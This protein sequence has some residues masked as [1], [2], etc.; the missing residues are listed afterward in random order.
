MDSSADAHF[1]Q[2]L[3]QVAVAKAPDLMR[4]LRGQVR[5]PSE[6]QDL[7]QELYV[8]I[9]K[10]KSLEEIRSPQAYLYRIAANLAFEHRRRC[11]DRPIHVTLDDIRHERQDTCASAPETN[12][13]EAGAV[14]AQRLECLRVRLSELSPRVQAAVLWHH[15][16]GYTCD[17]I[18][19]KL[20]VVTHRV[21]K[22]LAKGLAHCR[23]ATQLRRTSLESPALG[24][25]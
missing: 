2:D 25:Q 20:S 15:R 4:F 10:V 11:D 14:T 22:Y 19:R 1:R 9:L 3:V 6:A 13:L 8:R 23:G 21:K 17:E 7:L 16:D 18:A 5:Q 24:A 12:P